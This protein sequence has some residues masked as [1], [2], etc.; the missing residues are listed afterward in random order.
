MTAT[1]HPTKEQV[2]AWLAR[3]LAARTV[4]P[5]PEQ[6]RA[7]LHWHLERSHARG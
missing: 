3:Q 5:P 1:T 6:V 2:R 4:P 7:E